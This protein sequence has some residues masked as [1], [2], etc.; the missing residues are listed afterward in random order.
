MDKLEARELLENYLKQSG[1]KLPHTDANIELKTKFDNED[2]II[3]Q[4]TFK[5]LLK[6][7]YDF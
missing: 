1:G 6:I 5:W 4:Y 7:V 3:E 2:F